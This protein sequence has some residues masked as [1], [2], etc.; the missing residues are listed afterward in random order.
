MRSCRRRV[1]LPREETHVELKRAG[2]I[3]LKCTGVHYTRLMWLGSR[4]AG[5]LAGTH[6]WSARRR[7]MS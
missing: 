6:F 2:S 5:A 3:C 4:I 7:Y 1:S